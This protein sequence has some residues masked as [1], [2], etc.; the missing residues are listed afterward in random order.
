[1]TLL[2]QLWVLLYCCASIISLLLFFCYSV[3]HCQPQDA[4]QR[5]FFSNFCSAHLFR[6]T[7]CL[8]HCHSYSGARAAGK[9]SCQKQLY[10]MIVPESQD[11]Q[12]PPSVSVGRGTSQQYSSNPS[13]SSNGNISAVNTSIHYEPQESDF[14]LPVKLY[15]TAR[16]RRSMR[17]KDAGGSGAPAETVCSMVL[18]ILVPF[19]LA[20]LGI[21]SAGMLLEVVQVR[22]QKKTE[23]DKK[24]V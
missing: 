13:Y 16:S 10:N 24:V 20:G 7:A 3:S 1:M 6:P 17:A 21:V 11:E 18:Q 8:G 4:F 19:L 2:L 9:T 12:L 5:R 14:L 23:D 22:K 15:G